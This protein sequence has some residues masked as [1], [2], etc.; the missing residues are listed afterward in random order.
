MRGQLMRTAVAAD[1]ECLC[2]VLHGPSHFNKAAP[3]TRRED[4]AASE[5]CFSNVRTRRPLRGPVQDPTHA[6]GP[7][8][9]CGGGVRHG[10]G[11]ARLTRS[12][13]AAPGLGGDSPLSCHSQAQRIA[14]PRGGGSL[15][16][17]RCSRRKPRALLRS[18]SKGLHCGD[19]WADSYPWLS[20]TESA[21]FSPRLMLASWTG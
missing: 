16:P 21:P 13:I 4:V 9:V 17:W 12:K 14:P 7:A 2:G 8:C 18:G 15:L 6:W 1:A 5:G 3:S 10:G 20:R 19:E 11:A